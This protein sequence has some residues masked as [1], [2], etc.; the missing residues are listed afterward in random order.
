M[1][2]IAIHRAVFGDVNGAHGLQ[3]ASPGASEEVLQD[4]AW[5]YT[6]RLLPTEVPWAPYTCG[7]ALK[8]HYVL[9]RTFSVKASRTGMVQTHAIFLP[10][11]E[12]GEVALLSRLLALLPDE[13]APNISPTSQLV[14]SELPTTGANER[15]PPPEIPKGYCAVVR[16]M[17]DNRT[18]AWLGQDRFQEVVCCLWFRLWPE[19]RRS[20]AFRVAAEPSDLHDFPV[21][22]V[23]TPAALQMNWGERFLVNQTALELPGMSPAERFLMGSPSGATIGETL[24]RL[25]LAPRKLEALRRVEKYAELVGQDTADSIRAAARLLGR[26]APERTQAIEEKAQV[27]H[28]LASRTKS[29][30]EEDI[31]GLRNLDTSPFAT[32]EVE[33]E[34][35]ITEWLRG[36]IASEG[37]ALTYAQEALL[38]HHPWAAIARAATL[39]AF[40]PLSSKAA[41]LLWEWWQGDFRLVEATVSLFG[42]LIQVAQNELVQHAPPKLAKSVWRPI[43]S[44]IDGLNCYLLS[45]AVL[46]AADGP[47]ATQKLQSYL[48]TGGNDN[49]IE[50]IVA[51]LESEEVFNAA[52]H[53]N[54]PQLWAIGGRLAVK[55][56]SLMRKLDAAHAGWR[57][58]WAA[59]M[60][61]SVDVFD[62]IE[63]PRAASY[64]LLDA[65]LDGVDIASDLVTK[66]VISASA[67]ICE[68]PRRRDVWRLLSGSTANE[69]LSVAGRAWLRHAVNDPSFDPEGP[70]PDLAI[71]VAEV[72]RSQPEMVSAAALPALLSRVPD[73]ANEADFISWLR[74]SGHIHAGAATA[75]GQLVLDKY[76]P[77]A[78]VA[79]WEF[80]RRGRSELGPAVRACSSLLGFVDRAKAALF[81]RERVVSLDEWWEE[82]AELSPRLYPR[83]IRDQNI[84]EEA[85]GDESRVRDGSSREQWHD[86][87]DR[88]RKGGAGK[89]M[90]VPG[91]LHQMR[92]DFPNNPDLKLLED[93]YLQ[94]FQER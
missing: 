50:L 5:R 90:T 81:L 9:S 20:L 59:R 17:L 12:C 68:Y 84:W 74:A 4:L 94:D 64:S 75:L 63:E 25:E 47:T 36:C 85:D 18:P 86:A 76:W 8:G 49:G 70:E 57:A 30:S 6:D 35:A 82:F 79:L 42:Q 19:A 1:S 80:A 34:N 7:Y 55:K 41:T 21:D 10:Q 67:G 3:V 78:A 31:L 23:C 39:K 45:A 61:H 29:G 92:R 91:L 14:I 40:T 13:A 2:T 60:S 62:G 22:L 38:A 46:A 16:A 24:Q 44:S 77:G 93:L 72:W 54:N 43:L 71:A 58:V 27:V 87:L 66:V 52:L 83:G 37:G 32:A 33:L 88:L 51:R 69:A 53:L 26:L 28:Q 11:N 73:V 89:H 65:L 56:P 48:D 15:T